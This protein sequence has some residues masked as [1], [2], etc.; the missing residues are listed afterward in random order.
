LAGFWIHE[1]IETRRRAG[2][3]TDEQQYRA[4]LEER[5]R[6]KQRMLDVLFDAGLLPEY[7]PRSASQVPELNAELH[8]AIIGFLAM[9]PSQLLLVNQEDLTKETSQ[10][11]MPATTSQ[12]P[13]WSRKMRFT[14]EELKSHP[15]A[16]DFTAM[17]RNWLEETGRLNK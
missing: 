16:L 13:N 2:L 3:F 1:D 7:F 12:H 5:G 6:E 4:Q 9:T 17:F 10:Q 8:N 11:N 15:A 14:V